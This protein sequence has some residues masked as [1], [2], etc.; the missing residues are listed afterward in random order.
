MVRTATQM[1]ARYVNDM[2]DWYNINDLVT[3]MAVW[4]E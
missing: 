4:V 1:A 3:K 2:L